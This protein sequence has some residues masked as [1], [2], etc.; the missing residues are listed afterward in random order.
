MFKRN[1]RRVKQ[2]AQIKVDQT[3]EMEPAIPFFMNLG[4]GFFN[5]TKS[6]S[7]DIFID[8]AS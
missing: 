5:S 1:R 2:K 4:H 3:L 8:A 7:G 6:S